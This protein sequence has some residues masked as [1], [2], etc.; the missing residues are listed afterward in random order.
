MKIGVI[1]VFAM[2]CVTVAAADQHPA[3]NKQNSE[4]Q[5]VLAVEQSWIKAEVEH[6]QATLMR[7]LDVS[8][9]ATFGPR[10]PIDK[11]TFIAEAMRFTFASQKVTHD[12]V[13]VDGDTA[14]VVG[15]DTA[16]SSDSTQKAMTFRYTTMYLKRHG[17]WVAIAEQMGLVVAP[18]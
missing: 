12:V 5:R 3:S 14:V 17:K 6:D 9:V 18:Q 1:A 11:A 13:H 7:I 16:F 15:T 10:K 4:E 8:F 2:L